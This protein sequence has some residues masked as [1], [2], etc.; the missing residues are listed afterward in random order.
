MDGRI[1]IGRRRAPIVWLDWD[2]SDDLEGVLTQREILTNDARI[3]MKPSSPAVLTKHCKKWT[4]RNVLLF[5]EHTTE[6]RRHS[7]HLEHAGR[8][9]T[10]L[11]VF[12]CSIAT[13][14]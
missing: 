9:K 13:H 10:N 3:R 5:G 4:V 2:Y 1:K 11:K 7:A 6:D 12:R 8:D 14:I